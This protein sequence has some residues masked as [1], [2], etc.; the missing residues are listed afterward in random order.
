MTTNNMTETHL[1][2]FL[3]PGRGD[4]DRGR[5]RDVPSGALTHLRLVTSTVQYV[6]YS[7][8]LVVTYQGKVQY[9]G[10]HEMTLRLMLQ[11]NQLHSSIH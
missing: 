1:F 2:R 5:L 4:G 6:G 10:N 7:S 11:D 9:A 8:P 3:A